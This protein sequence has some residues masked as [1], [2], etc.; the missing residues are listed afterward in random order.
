MGNLAAVVGEPSQRTFTR[1]A[2]TSPAEHQLSLAA[3]GARCDEAGAA[4]FKISLPLPLPE[5]SRVCE[6]RKR[7]S[8]SAPLPVRFRLAEFDRLSGSARTRALQRLC[9]PLTVRLVDLVVEL[10]QAGILPPRTQELKSAAQPTA[11]PAEPSRTPDAA[12]TETREERRAIAAR[13][14][15]K[16]A[17]GL[18]PS[19]AGGTREGC[20]SASARS[21]EKARAGLLDEL[22]LFRIPKRPRT[23]ADEP[24]IAGVFA[25]TP[26]NDPC[27]RDTREHLICEPPRAECV[28]APP[29]PPQQPP[30]PAEQRIPT[31]TSKY[32]TYQR[33]VELALRRSSA[34]SSTQGDKNLIELT[35][36]AV[37]EAIG[38]SAARCKSALLSTGHMASSSPRTNPSLLVLQPALT[39]PLANTLF[40]P[41]QSLHSPVSTRTFGLCDSQLWII[42]H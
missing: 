30:P 8:P 12:A 7:A 18:A 31:W 42:S 38:E 5:T 24:P 41:P 37:G 4:S 33:P 3:S 1:A 15:F 17:P 19:E 23:L 2:A 10:E 35:P 26:A 36:G 28:R 22:G 27:W 14:A 13:H 40:M 21:S 16:R 29:Q 9:R 6:E 25:V 32:I 34:H 20:V 11:P 39:L